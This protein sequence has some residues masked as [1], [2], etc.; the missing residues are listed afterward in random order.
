MV[1]IASAIASSVYF[2][3]YFSFLLRTV[4]RWLK[5]NS[6]ALHSGEYGGWK[7]SETPL[8][9]RIS[10]NKGSTKATWWKPQLSITTT[11]F[12]A[13]TGLFSLS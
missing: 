3:E 8:A 7:M 12:G 5:H 9:A 10:R 11:L 1:E 6:H 2:D 13:N 4:L